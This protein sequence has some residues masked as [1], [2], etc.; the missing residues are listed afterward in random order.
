MGLIEGLGTRLIEGQGNE[1]IQTLGVALFPGSPERE[2]YMRVGI[3]PRDITRFETVY[4]ILLNIH[5]SLPKQGHFRRP[6]SQ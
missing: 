1:A 6:F 3:F 4:V 2:M 5:K